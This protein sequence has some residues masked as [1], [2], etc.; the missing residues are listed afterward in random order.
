MRCSL[1][2]FHF[3]RVFDTDMLVC[4]N[5]SQ[6]ARKIKNASPT[7]KICFYI[8]LLGWVITQACCVFLAF[9]L[10]NTKTQLQRIA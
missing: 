5:A 9:L 10:T 8:T 7:R 1:A 2:F 4:Q 6:N 3:P